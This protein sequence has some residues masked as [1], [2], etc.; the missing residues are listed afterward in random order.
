MPMW[1]P[2][3][4]LDQLLA[5]VT[6]GTETGIGKGFVPG[7]RDVAVEVVPGGVVPAIDAPDPVRRPPLVFVHMF[8]LVGTAGR[9]QR[10]DAGAEKGEVGLCPLLIGN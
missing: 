6:S 10:C 5:G 2:M 3:S 4:P 1:R 8:D 7:A 9:G